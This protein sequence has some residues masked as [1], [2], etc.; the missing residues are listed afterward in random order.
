[1]CRTPSSPRCTP[2]KIHRSSLGP[3]LRHIP[4]D[5]P[6][7]AKRLRPALSELPV[8]GARP[9]AALL[10]GDRRAGRAH[11]SAPRASADIDAQT[12]ER[13]PAARDA[14]RQ[15]DGG[16]GGGVELGGG[17]VS[18]TGTPAQHR[19]QTARFRE[20]HLPYTDPGDGAR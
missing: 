8:R 7:R 16:A 10:G 14:Q 18:P 15:G 1:M 3:R 9:H 13:H 2:P 5:Q 20:E 17:R 11:R 6:E 12:L 19:K 4:G